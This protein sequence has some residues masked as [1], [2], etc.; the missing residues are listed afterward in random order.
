[1]RL[2]SA[3]Y[4]NKVMAIYFSDH[5]NSLRIEIEFQSDFSK[6]VFNNYIPF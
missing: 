6:F 2:I 3:V 4:H 5:W 1:M